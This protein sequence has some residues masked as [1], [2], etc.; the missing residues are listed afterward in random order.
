MT[1]DPVDARK[2]LDQIEAHTLGRLLGVLK[3]KISLDEHLAERFASALRAR[4]RL[5]QGFYE[6]H[7]F[8]IQTEEGRNVMIADLEE[9][10]EE[11]FQVWRISSVLTEATAKI[12]IQLRNNP[13]TE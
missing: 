4:N 12:I 6:R 7:N 2:A 13:P 3:G 11:L 9:L 8:K 10:H 5:N 1:P